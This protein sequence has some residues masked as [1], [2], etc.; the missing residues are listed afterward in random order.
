MKNNQKRRVR[1][2]R[3]MRPKDI[4]RRSRKRVSAT[5][6][7]AIGINWLMR[8]SKQILMVLESGGRGTIQSAE[9]V[10]LEVSRE[11]GFVG[12]FQLFGATLRHGTHSGSGTCV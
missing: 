8:P 11:A 10:S 2:K 4:S 1:M 9:T 7:A 5:M 3:R 12:L 6:A